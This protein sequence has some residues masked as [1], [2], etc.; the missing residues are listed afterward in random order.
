MIW[1]LINYQIIQQYLIFETDSKSRIPER[2]V[3]SK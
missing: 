2:D 1:N 3:Q